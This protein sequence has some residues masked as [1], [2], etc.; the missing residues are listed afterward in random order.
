[1]ELDGSTKTA[2]NGE[3]TMAPGTAQA[4]IAELRGLNTAERL[5]GLYDLG[6]DGCST[7]DGQTVTAVL[8]ELIESLDFQYAD[9]SVG[10]ERIYN[11]CLE[12]NRLGARDNVAFV[13]RDLRDTLSTS[14]AE[15]EQAS[16]AA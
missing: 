14:A 2:S 5:L 15:S 13:L 4:T 10:F 1:M 7:G 16:S 8:E 12:Q 11:Y 6:L 3:D 9:I